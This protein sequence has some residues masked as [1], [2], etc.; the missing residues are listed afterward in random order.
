MP[1]LA[2][3]LQTK[4]LERETL[5]V[6]ST[7]YDTSLHTALLHLLGQADPDGT[8]R[9]YNSG[10][11]THIT[12]AVI[13]STA[14]QQMMRVTVSGQYAHSVIQ[15]LF[16]ML[17]EQP[18][19]YGGQQSYRVLSA[20]FAQAASVTTNTWADLLTPSSELTLRLRF[21]TPAVFTG[22]AGDLFQNECFPQPLQVFSKLI[23]KWTWLGGP[24]LEEELL[25]WLRDYGCFVSAYQ[26][27]A[28]PIRLRTGA[29]LI[30]LSPGWKGWITYRCQRP[31]ADRMSTLRS[32]ARL[33]CFTGVGAYT[34]VGL[35]ITRIEENS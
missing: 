29:G 28:Q 16:S 33:A 9:L 14:D 8:S 25:P 12:V 31:H 20:D 27:G 19:L 17:T 34:E 13:K 10:T 21:E 3:H 35:G 24:K 7:P 23:E 26:L 4:P 11:S 15:A 30:T 5:H 18:V 6:E 2:L 32:L 1:F 22:A